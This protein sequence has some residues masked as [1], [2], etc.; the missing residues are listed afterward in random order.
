MADHL[1]LPR[2][3]VIDSRRAGGGGGEAHKQ[4]PGVHGGKL[5]QE[6]AQAV[7]AQ[8]PVRT[9]DGVDPALV[10]KVRTHSGGVD[11]EKL[12]ESGFDWL[13]NTKDWTYFL[14][15]GDGPGPFKEKLD[16][17]AAAGTKRKGAPN[18]TFFEGIIEILPY[19]REDRQ[20]PGV[21]DED[22]AGEA[23]L[24][25]DV[26]V[27]PS[28]DFDTARS[29]L[30]SVREVVQRHQGTVLAA[31]EGRRFTIARVRASSDCVSELLDLAVVESI[32]TSP[33]PRLEPTTWRFATAQ[34]LPEPERREVAPIGLIDDEVMDHPLLNG[35]IVSRT[36]MPA[37]HD[38]QPPTD[39][40][41]L[42]AGLLVLGDIEAAL[43]G[44][45]SWV[46]VGPVHAVRV[47]EPNPD[48]P[49]EAIFPTDRPV[50]LVIE[51][52]IRELHDRY[53]V[54]IFN[55][56]I[57]DPEAFSG[58]HLSIW[59]ERMDELAR[60]LDAV[61]VVAAGNYRVSDLEEGVD[62]LSGYPAYLL[63]D[64]ARVAE[65]GAAANVLTVGAL[66][67][68]DAP[69]RF[70]G[71]VRP[72]DRA[73][74]GA[75]APAP[76][77]RS[78]PGAAGG[79]KP[80]VTHYGGNWVLNDVDM[81]EQRDH[82]V[83]I[84]SLNA[85]EGKLFGIAN[86][87]SFSAPRVTRVAA[88]VLT[89]Y[90]GSSANLIRALLGAATQPV[91]VPDSLDPKSLRR[92]AGYGVLVDERATDSGRS[93]VAMI[94]EGEIDPDTAVIHPVPIP[95]EFIEASGT[96]RIVVS[97]AFDP[98]VRRTRREYLTANMKV[99]L[100]RG[101][102][103]EEITEIWKKQPAKD[104]GK[105]DLPTGRL[106]PKLDPGSQECQDATLQV[107]SYTRQ[108]TDAVDTHG[109]HVIVQHLAASWASTEHPQRYA[110][111]VVLE[112]RERENVDLRALL[113]VRLEER[114][115]VRT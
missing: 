62:A 71:T 35:S 87:T 95:N 112:D 1:R 28:P 11:E 25:F 18:L 44:E 29:R 55:L 81:V 33:V 41:T 53:G 69:Q 54:R 103:M 2:P 38:W 97:L 110:L 99:D 43:A 72:G 104:K 76:F 46:A 49:E 42:V 74:A 98:E 30:K 109:Y 100:A 63:G 13:G 39:H 64:S 40:G 114:L 84:V 47:L 14:L 89:R 7:E 36:A 57:A 10:F 92:S 61:I 60:E 83:S 48:E 108:N 90:P 107:R 5:Q 75:G 31:D 91:L 105:K 73:I 22:L 16:A 52:A 85:R 77:T 37:D 21:S 26:I 102:S 65:P 111:V 58:P 115:R 34:D 3:R 88:E 9:K 19:S 68:A 101:L 15:A 23:E 8:R 20:G 6:L 45:R 78:G 82:G 94:Y 32:R 12:K 51:E 24:S 67:H 93:R 17:Y 79:I 50:Q 27:W 96:R 106:R 113:E 70:D 80:D 4:Q 86:G 56:S 66:A 59:S